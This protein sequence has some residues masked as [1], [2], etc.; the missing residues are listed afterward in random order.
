MNVHAANKL[1]DNDTQLESTQDFTQDVGN[2]DG[3]ERKKRKGFTFAERSL[4]A[5]YRL[6]INPSH[7]AAWQHRHSGHWNVKQIRGK[8]VTCANR[9]NNKTFTIKWFND[10]IHHINIEWMRTVIPYKLPSARHSL[11][12]IKTSIYYVHIPWTIYIGPFFESVSCR[13][14]AYL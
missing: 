5:D 2:D 9:H 7:L 6:F 11:V 3:Q 1:V 14:R 8:V 12:H 13:C 4:C 10:D